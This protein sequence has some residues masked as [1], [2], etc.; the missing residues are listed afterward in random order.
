MNIEDIK[1]LSDDYFGFDLSENKRTR[2]LI[3]ARCYYYKF[4]DSFIYGVSL[5]KIGKQVSSTKSC[6]WHSNVLHGLKKF[7]EL[8]SVDIKYR[9]NYEK[10]E[11]FLLRKLK[12]EKI[13]EPLDVIYKKYIAMKGNR[14]LWKNKCTE[15][16][17]KLIHSENKRLSLKRRNSKI[18]KD[19]HASN[20]KKKFYKLRDENKKLQNELKNLTRC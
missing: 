14:T 9:S 17:K 4:C 13:D 10:Y 3:D 16:R 2:E 8:N 15:T 18:I 20:W 1:N 7:K 11:D 19:Y 6:S 12:V 5:S